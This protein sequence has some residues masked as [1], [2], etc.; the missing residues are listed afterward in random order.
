MKLSYP[1]FS[2]LWSWK[3]IDSKSR[4]NWV[5]SSLD[6]ASRIFILMGKKIVA[7]RNPFTPKFKLFFFFVH[8]FWAQGFWKSVTKVCTTRFLTSVYTSLSFQLGARTL[9]TS[10]SGTIYGFRTQN[11]IFQQR[12][13][14]KLNTVEYLFNART[15]IKKNS[16]KGGR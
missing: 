11:V 8:T 2:L 1:S 7:L 9:S 15:E 5:V 10:S 12:W 13:F 3:C 16:S 6:S 4:E 14:N